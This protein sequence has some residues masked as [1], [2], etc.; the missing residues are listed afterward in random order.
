MDRDRPQGRR[1]GRTRPG[2][3]VS[4]GHAGRPGRTCGVV[5][6]CL[7]ATVAAGPARAQTAAPATQT[8]T[9]GQPAGTSAGK[10]ATAVGAAVTLQATASS[11]RPVSF[12]SD[13]PLVCAI[14]RTALGTTV[15][16]VAA[17]VCAITAFQAGS[18]GLA[19]APEVARAFQVGTG[20]GQRTVT[21]G[22]PAGTQPGRPATM[23]GAV[24]ALTA[25]VP[26]D[27]RAPAPSPGAAPEP[28]QVISFRSDTPAVCTVSGATTTSVT[29]SGLTTTGTA[30]AVGA[31]ACMITATQPGDSQFAAAGA[32][33]TFQVGTGAGRQDVSFPPLPGAQVGER[34]PLRA[35]ASSGLPVTFR[36][37]TPAVCTVSGAPAT[38]GPSTGAAVAVGG[39]TCTIT[40][41]QP[42]DSQF[43]AAGAAR[44]FQVGTGPEPQKITFQ[45]PEGTRAP[46]TAG[47]PV[48]LTASASSGLPVSFRSDTPLVCAVPGATVLTLAAGRCTITAAQG[49]SARF[50]AA[51]AGHRSFTVQAGQEAQQIGLAG[52]ASP[53]S[54]TAAVEPAG[55]AG[56]LPVTAT[57]GLA[58]T[59]RAGT[60]LVPQTPACSV[61]G[62]TVLTLAAGQC[63]ITA[64]QGGSQDFA[65]ASLP[66]EFAVQAGGTWPQSIS[67]LAVPGRAVV[68]VPLVVSAQ[69]SSG[70]A[71]SFRAGAREVPAG[72]TPPPVCQVS[73]A[74]I[75]P[76][77]PGTCTVVAFQAGSFQSA[78]LKAAGHGSVGYEAAEAPPQ[79]IQVQDT[80]T[81]SFARP[82]SAVAGVTVPL[83]ATASS[84]LPVTF[85]SATPKTCEVSG[86]TVSTL[87]A[88]TCTITAFQDGS[89]DYVAAPD[90]TRS[91]QVKATQTIDF[92][93]PGR[94]VPGLRIPLAATASSRLPVSFHT[95]TPD[96]CT[97]SAT[98]AR[99]LAPGTCII[100]AAQGGNADYAPAPSVA[101]SFTVQAGTRSQ[102]ITFTPPPG[103]VVGRPIVLFARATSKL[104]VSF[105]SDTP[106]VCTVSGATVTARAAGL[107]TITASQGGSAAFRPATDVPRSLEIRAGPQPQVIQ[108]GTPSP[109]RAGSLV[110]LIATA[111]S[112]LPVAFRSA[113]LPV[114]TVSGTAVTAA[115]AGLCTIT[116]FQGGSALYRAAPE[117]TRS[118]QV[119]AGKVTQKITFAQPDAAVTG[120]AVTLLATAT[121][122]LTVSFRADTPACAVS[123]TTVIAV[124][125]G[126]CT[127]TA[128]QGGS[129]RYSAAQDVARTFAVRAGRQAQTISFGPPP[130]ALAGVPVTPVAWASSGLPVAFRS[131]SPSVC[132]VS[133]TAV[134]TL[135]A[136]T[137]AIT[138]TQGGNSDFAAARRVTQSFQIRA[139]HNAQTID[140]GAP[141]AA[142][143]GTQVTLTA[144]ASSGLPVSFSSATPAVCTVSGTTVTTV[145][146]GSCTITASQGGSATYAAARAVT[147][148]FAVG[149]GHKSQW[150]IFRTPPDTA[151][152]HPAV[153]TASASSGLPV[154]FS[155]ATPAVCTV[156]GTTVT[157]L[158]AGTC[159][160]TATQGGSTLYAAA[161][162]APRSFQVNPAAPA[163]PAALI[164]SLAAAV[165][166]A[167]GLAA[168]GGVL[169]LRRRRLRRRD[170]P[171]AAAAP[172]VHAEPHPGPPGSSS[173]RTT[174][175]AATHIVRINTQRGAGTVM[176][177]E[178]PH[179][180]TV[181][182]PPRDRP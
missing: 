128:S 27:A 159:T 164:R 51:R 96:V 7:L 24:V 134:T 135:T 137:C 75:I 170:R 122:G 178:S 123:G 54:G 174:G 34:V 80:Q 37:D 157:T 30:T 158:T 89:D 125:A 47:D 105:R 81:I 115:A 181:A 78:N 16:P 86:T 36:S 38:G 121:S 182:S 142:G 33:R 29:T 132:T 56:Y 148:S 19:A 139:G 41:T 127:I 144:A 13:T 155:S 22:Q 133:G 119:T 111:S 161:R 104:P 60:G 52:G 87:A 106:A 147:H 49:G 23:V 98:A 21:F 179:A 44:A 45:R 129:A 91:F 14:S 66:L 141:A 107:C 151:V 118:F 138:A 117:V 145:A 99:T 97:V 18:A 28:G 40:A 59:L 176:I 72:T 113:S 95:S 109:A 46:V 136:G 88:G 35:R 11:G 55:V 83:T 100:T 67:G 70:L 108:F 1:P 43:A 175:A 180:T 74:T 173:T 71:V 102:T 110:P 92:T 126:G 165:L 140:F 2:S 9:F 12:R 15:T 171:P 84:G 8:I 62:T 48:T 146:P 130:E 25:S 39:G 3:K 53:P 64:V 20:A 94:A 26:P 169:A 149:A 101:R 77:T 90:S 177:R 112:G 160:I 163:I 103:T 6:I 57:S 143:V 162:A 152:G 167:A 73:G 153:L 61:S 10:P 172:T 154:S 114:C 65:S 156:S 150:I 131:E 31:G 76:L 120:A 68:G 168:A 63:S 4:A 85:R 69:A 50:A 17:G 93:Q 79:S 42:G 58:V 116:A 5:G 32:A 166:A 82:R 124:A